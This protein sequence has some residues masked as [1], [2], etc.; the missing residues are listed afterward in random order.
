MISSEEF[1][2]KIYDYFKANAKWPL[3]R[4]WQINLRHEG[5]IRR[6]AAEAG[7][8]KVICE[9]T[10]DGV[11]FLYLKGIVTC[12]GSDNDI[13]NYL[14]TIRIIASHYISSGKEMITSE[15]IQKELGLSENDINKVGEILY[16]ETGIW[17]S[18]SWPQDGCKFQLEPTD[19]IV[20]FET[21]N[22]VNA[23]W[24]VKD[25]VSAERTE[26]SRM[27]SNNYRG[28]DF[29]LGLGSEEEETVPRWFDIPLAL[30]DPS[31][32]ELLERDL[33]ELEKVLSIEAWKA[34]S[35]LAGSCLEAVLLDLWKR[36]EKEAKECFG[37][38]WPNHVNSFQLATTAAEKGYLSKDHKD[39]ASTIRRWRNL[40]HPAAALN[41]S[42]PGRELAE[43]LIA[44]LKLLL[45]EIV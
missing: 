9:E 33:G 37:S 4:E 21:I 1:L 14:A 10:K 31:L 25:Q 32:Q 18:F 11:C 3:V 27:E 36:R 39:L 6:I 13:M 42:Q 30:S 35:I 38:K 29:A 40:V 20:F 15:A 24:G 23:Y 19:E 43:A 28:T 8:D 26:A 12:Q 5:N 41:E 17:S 7:R 45:V 44:L 2:Q 34:A 16:R 22:T